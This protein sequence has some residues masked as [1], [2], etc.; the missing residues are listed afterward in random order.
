MLG[1]LTI[2]EKVRLPDEDV[3]NTLQLI[4]AA[5]RERTDVF[6]DEDMAQARQIFELLLKKALG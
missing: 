4:Q 2:V 3:K 1:A 5:W 6:V